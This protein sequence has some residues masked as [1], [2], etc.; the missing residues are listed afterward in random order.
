MVTK[1]LITLVVLVCLIL[2]A[3]HDCLAQYPQDPEPGIPEPV[4]PPVPRQ[5]PREKFRGYASVI[6]ESELPWGLPDDLMQRLYDSATAY[7]EYTRRFTCVETARQA[8]YDAAGEATDE[9]KRSYGYLLLK[10][11]EGERLREYRQHIAKDGTIKKGEVKDREPFPPAYAWVFMFSHFN[12]PYFAFRLLDDRFDGFDW[13]YEIEFKGS[14]PFTNGKDIRE[15]EGTILVDAVTHTPLEINAQP[16][17][18]RERI[19]AYFRRWAQAFD[20][21][22]IKLAPRPLGY[23]AAIRFRHR[24]E[25]LSFPTELRYDTIRAV[26]IDAIR[27]VRASIRTYDDY[28]ITRVKTKEEVGEKTRP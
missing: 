4:R 8:N 7:R 18:Q 15:W 26:G 12:E 22:G 23:Q 5:P 2:P 24:R 21:I 9:N 10:E 11:P 19:D 25:G 17:G 1:Y 27:L 16:V 20:L 3:A 13:V 28:R 14:L 6:S